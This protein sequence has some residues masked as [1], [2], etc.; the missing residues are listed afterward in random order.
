MANIISKTTE[1][2]LNDKQERFCELY[3][4]ER[5]FFGN[6]VETYIEVYDPDKTKPNWYKTSCARASQLLSNIKVI[7]RIN[8]LLEINGLNDAFVDKQ[9]HFLV[10]QH[11][12]FGNKLGAIKEY[13]KLKQRITDKIDHLSGG[14]PFNVEVIKFAEPNVSHTNNNP[15]SEAEA[16][17]DQAGRDS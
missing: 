14:K 3:A 17:M 4:T 8:D 6:G 12:D 5:E 1:S 13:N 16:G 15:N 7:T 11:A 9:L 2:G 10:T